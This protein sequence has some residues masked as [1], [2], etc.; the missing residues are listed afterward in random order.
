MSMSKKD[1]DIGIY[2]NWIQLCNKFG[3]YLYPESREE[4]K[5]Y[6]LA[7]QSHGYP[8]YVRHAVT[9]RE[10]WMFV[11]KLLECETTQDLQG[12]GAGTSASSLDWQLK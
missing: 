8:Y 12:M 11:D 7:M 3:G 10:N 6:A 5:V 9:K 2:C 4:A 1:K